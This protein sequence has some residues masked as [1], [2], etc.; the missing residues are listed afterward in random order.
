V[1]KR[2]IKKIHTLK[3]RLNMSDEEYRLRL[4]D[5]WVNT[6]KNLSYE[7]AEDLI[8]RLEREAIQKGVW[9]RY[10]L[11]GKMKYEDL[12]ERTGMA[13][14]RQLRMIEAMWRDVSY[15]HDPHRRERALRRFLFR[16]TGVHDLRFL[17]SRDV[18][19]VVN[20]MKHMKRGW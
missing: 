7:E 14:P 6:S 16:I 10:S 2:Q 20:A 8:Q 19:K 3:S 9:S 1:T 4:S 18:R 17:R 13:T 15:T 11:R 5:Y 12:G